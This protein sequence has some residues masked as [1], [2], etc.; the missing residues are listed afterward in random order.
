MAIWHAI[1]HAFS[2]V[3]M[4]AKKES[5]P[6][7]G[8][9]SPRFSESKFRELVLYVAAKS[10]LD[11]KFGITK[12]NKI[13][14]ASDFWAYGQLGQ[15][16]TRATYKNR[17][18]GPAPHEFM[19]VTQKMIRDQELVFETAEFHGKEQKRPVALR[20]PDLNGFTAEEIAVVDETLEAL[21]DAT[22]AGVS[23]WTH[24]M[25][26]WLHTTVGE[27]IPYESV[28]LGDDK[29]SPELLA[30]ATQRVAERHLDWEREAAA[31]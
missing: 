31:R 13:L 20:K 5:A 11:P 25:R 21:S 2:V 18:F 6:Y 17:E 1:E 19:P 3:L 22:A 4:A 29:L 30:F 8:P 16:I 7:V 26:G 10:R 24:N 23:R 15:S 27:A 9:Y 28:F 12:L 14:W